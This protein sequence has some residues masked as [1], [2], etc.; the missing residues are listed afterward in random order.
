MDFQL[1]Q[2]NDPGDET[3]RNFRYQHAYGVILLISA[4]RGSLPYCNIWCEFYEDFLCERNDGLLDIYQVKTRKPELG[5]WSLKDEPLRHSIKRFVDQYLIFGERIQKFYF[6]S[7]ADFPTPVQYQNDLNRYANSPIIFVETIKTTDAIENIIDPFK[8]VFQNLV[9]YCNCGEDTLFT[10]LKRI[11]FIKGPSREGFDAEIAHEHLTDLSQCATLRP[12]DLNYIRDELISKIYFASSL[13]IEDPDRH[14]VPLNSIG[15]TSPQLYAKRIPLTLLYEVIEEAKKRYKNEQEFGTEIDSL[16][17]ICHSSPD[18]DEFSKWLSFQ[19]INAGYAVWCDLINQKPGIDPSKTAEQVIQTHT[20]KFL[21]VISNATT[22]SPQ[23]Q[24]ELQVAYDKMKSTGMDGFI[25]PIKLEEVQNEIFLLRNVNSISFIDSW[26]NGFR[27]LNKYFEESNFK[28]S[29]S[30]GPTETNQIW[31]MLLDPEQGIYVS[32]EEYLSNWFKIEK[33]PECIYFH[34][35]KRISGIGKIELPPTLPYPAFQHINYLVSFTDAKDFN[36]TIGNLTITSSI[37]IKVEDFLEGNFPYKFVKSVQA[38]KIINQLLNLGWEYFISKTNLLPYQMAN[39]KKC[40]Y[41]HMGSGN[42]M[43]SFEGSG[44]K[45]TRRSLIGFRTFSGMDGTKKKKYWHFGVTA[46]AIAFPEF[47]F[48]IKS[49][50]LFSDDGYTIWISK[51]RLHSARR[52]WCKDWWNDE[53]RDRLLA[54][55]STISM[56]QNSFSIPLGS[57]VNVIVK[58]Q[59]IIFT[60]PISYIGPK[61]IQKIETTEIDEFPDDDYLEDIPWEEESEVKNE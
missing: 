36:G 47:A 27:K 59:P 56:G 10:V 3:Q 14:I 12:K 58:S 40:W 4:G 26:A 22:K 2:S 42:S 35:L 30:T 52:S 51:D 15:L 28:K 48:V 21:L 5:L 19:L 20:S 53:W 31:R 18:D 61:E 29:I 6:V 32:P 43:V 24:S 44:D 45:K 11:G 8:K 50:V 7:N 54:M 39:G 46:K 9:S 41:Y 37:S 33:L 13:K 55:I 38:R 16:I 17:Y 25:I 23:T 1:V 57:N 60:S 49:H 34:E